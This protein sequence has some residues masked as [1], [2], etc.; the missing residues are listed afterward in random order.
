MR[1]DDGQHMIETTLAHPV[2]ALGRAPSMGVIG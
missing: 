2:L 1:L